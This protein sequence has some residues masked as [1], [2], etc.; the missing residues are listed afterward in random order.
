MRVFR[1]SWVEKT[2]VSKF[3]PTGELTIFFFDG[4]GDWV[5]LR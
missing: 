3:A 2:V 4:L 5:G 1:M